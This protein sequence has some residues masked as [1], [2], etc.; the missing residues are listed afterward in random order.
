M[1]TIPSPRRRTRVRA[2]NNIVQQPAAREVPHDLPGLVERTGPDWWRRE[3]QVLT[4][5]ER[6]L[7]EPFGSDLQKK[8]EDKLRIIS[9][10]ICS[11]GTTNNSA[12]AN[13]PKDTQIRTLINCTEADM[14][15][16]QEE[17]TNYDELP[18]NL[19]PN[20]RFR[21]SF[22]DHRCV[23]AHNIH[24]EQ[25]NGSTLPGG[26]SIRVINNLVR[27]IEQFSVDP[28][29]LGR[30]CSTRIRGKRGMMLSV[31]SAY[32]P[33]TNNRDKN[34]VYNQHSIYLLQQGDMT[35][36]V[37]GF[38]RDLTAS[39]KD[40]YDRGDQIVI[41]ADMN[42]DLKRS[43]LLQPFMESFN[44]QESILDMHGLD[45]PR[46]YVRGKTTID[47]IIAS[48]TLQVTGCGYLSPPQ[49]PGDHLVLWIDLSCASALGETNTQSTQ[50]EGRKLQ[51]QDPRVVSKYLENL[52][53]ASDKENLEHR[54]EALFQAVVTDPVNID[55]ERFHGILED[56]R[57]CMTYSEDHCRKINAGNLDW[58]T[59]LRNHQYTIAYWKMVIRWKQG[60]HIDR[61]FLQTAQLCRLDGITTPMECISLQR[62]HQI[63]RLQKRS[64][65][66]EAKRNH[67]P[68]R[69]T[70][71]EDLAEAQTDQADKVSAE[72]MKKQETRSKILKQLIQQEAA[73]KMHRMIRATKP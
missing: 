38:L 20:E 35:D 61:R 55:E 39:V 21:G 68:N 3:S 65:R 34:S 54:I 45:G 2:V 33:C 60:F 71:L 30:W 15:L 32:R 26:T 13:T 59:A 66:N 11:S 41:G 18:K 57:I 47:C 49:S 40:A 73:K 10:N 36:P 46:T 16:I 43:P 8:S 67:T 53:K 23:T 31:F 52:N 12:Q 5:E 24:A 29:G 17:N 22:Q 27:K 56:F 51:L 50:K 44:L 58:S 42:L 14:V 28:S 37:E 1:I 6:A 4:P 69:I 62:A 9:L 7:L 64:Y 48:R 72:V 70:F 19:H 25:G 63:L